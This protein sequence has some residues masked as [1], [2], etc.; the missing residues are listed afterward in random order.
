[1]VPS[2]DVDAF[3]VTLHCL[4]PTTL[5]NTIFRSPLLHC[6]A[7]LFGLFAV[8]N[9]ALAAA[10]TA[11]PTASL[12]PSIDCSESTCQRAAT[13]LS[14][15]DYTEAG[16]LF[17]AHAEAQSG[18][19]ETFGAWLVHAAYAYR[20]AEN[21]D[22]AATHYQRAAEAIEVLQDYLLTQAVYA[23]LHADGDE[24]LFAHAEGS[25]A[26]EAGYEGGYFLL[27]RLQARRADLPKPETVE[28]ALTHD[29]PEIV[30]PWLLQAL[31]DDD[32]ES[33]THHALFGL[34]YSHCIDEEYDDALANLT[35]TPS[36]TARLE[37]AVGLV[38]DVR[39]EDALQQLQTLDRDALSPTDRC[40]ADFRRARS[41]FFLRQRQA[42]EDLYRQIIEH[43][44]DEANE[45]QRVRSL[46]AVG[47]RN[48]QRG[49]LDEAEHFFTKL[50]E[51]YPH[52]SHADDALFFLARIER[53]RPEPDRQ[54]EIDLLV[55]A[56]EKYPW[57][58]M[59]HE[60]AWEVFE[61][62]F[63]RGD[64]EEFIDS[65]TALPLPNWDGEY[66]S[67]GR[68]EYFV[69][70]AHQRLGDIDDAE[71]YWQLAWVKYPFSFYGYLAH[72]RM[73][74][75]D[76]VPEQLHTLEADAP[77]HWFDADFEGTGADILARTGHL[78]GACDFESARLEH[79]E[80]TR[81]DRWRLATLCHQAGNYPLSHNIARRQIEGR[82]WSFPVNGRLAR[83]HIAWPDPYGSQL[84]AAIDSLG[85][86]GDAFI[87]PGL[88]S[89]I[90]REE[91]SFHE[92]IISWAGA[93]GLMQL[94]PATARDHDDAIDGIA[95][96]DRLETADINIRVG[97]DH[98][99]HLSRRYDG[100]PVLITAAYNAGAGRI[101][102]WLRRQPND[103]IGLWVED[104]PFLQTRNYT[105][106]VIGS[107]AAYQYL[108]GELTLDDRIVTPAR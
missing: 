13:A 32:A 68:L 53:G 96:P 47:N 104:I 73:L 83:W 86:T 40:R 9:P 6:I 22:E 61:P 36:P 101:N 84:A 2:G 55:E 57:E 49:R 69:G 7:A 90:M 107:Y 106:R 82:P 62:V 103:E 92:A 74:E 72:L 95:T 91:S 80:P 4:Q 1:M 59:I 63:R 3:S 25:G 10:D 18:D 48:Y 44:T 105:K 38:Q 94:M 56:L 37:R 108:Q 42:A 85:P 51:Q 77:D 71:R 24:A 89:S 29:D 65:V 66:F 46:Y 52:R 5:M 60:M 8:A 21:W 11:D 78:E 31:S 41:H 54:R 67:Q 20:L 97:I 99:A 87:H 75:H 79:T 12:V 88:A 35:N 33:D 26:L 76:R 17:I 19:D 50:Y 93:I 102:G 81:S 16:D 39:F 27:A 58:D 70:L 64:Y 23:S 15:R 14:E 28:A 43:C 34:A 100:H 45:T 98:I 30:C